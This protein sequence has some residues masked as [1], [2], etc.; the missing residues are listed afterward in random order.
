MIEIKLI[1]QKVSK[2][3]YQIINDNR[4]H[5]SE[6]L[7]WIKNTLNE[8]DSKTFIERALAIYN[9]KNGIFFNI[10]YNKHLCG[11]VGATRDKNNLD[12]FDINYWIDK[13]H[14]NRGI[15][16]H[17]TY[18][19][20]NY[21]MNKWRIRHFY[22]K[23]SDNNIASIRIAQKLDFHIITENINEDNTNGKCVTNLIF[24]KIYTR[25]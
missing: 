4:T 10:Y 3:L 19:L 21:L 15:A 8:N 2:E 17:A 9:E 18:L 7:P 24:E 16:T 14:C 13:S 22:I 6:W 12:Y 20:I 25:N 11:V 1:S 23:V 5:L